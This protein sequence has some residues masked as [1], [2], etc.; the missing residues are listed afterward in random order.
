M[1]KGRSATYKMKNKEMTKQFWNRVTYIKKSDPE[2]Y[3]MMRNGQLNSYSLISLL[4]M[5][6]RYGQADA[7]MSFIKLTK[8]I[9]EDFKGE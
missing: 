3:E 8:K 2:F 4:K 1:F 9:H 7:N 6:Y 5:F